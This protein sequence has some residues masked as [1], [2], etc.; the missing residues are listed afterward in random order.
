[1]LEAKELSQ[2]ETDAWTREFRSNL[3]QIDRGRRGQAEAPRPGAPD[4][5]GA[6]AP[7]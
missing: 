5:P 7:R 6:V 4:L 1:M 3:E 2:T